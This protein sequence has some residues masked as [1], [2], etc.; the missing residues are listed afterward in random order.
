MTPIAKKPK[1]RPRVSPWNHFSD[2]KTE[3][4]GGDIEVLKNSSATLVFPPES[5]Y[6]DALVAIAS[7]CDPPVAIESLNV[8]L[9]ELRYSPRG[10]TIFRFAGDAIDDIV[11]GAKGNYWWVSR[12]GLNVVKGP[13]PT[14]ALSPFDH[15]AG[16]LCL[17]KLSGN[18]LSR[19]AVREIAKALD[20]A[21]F[22][23]REQLQRAQWKQI[24]VHNQKYARQAVKTFEQAC[25]PTLVRWVRKRLYVARDRYKAFMPPST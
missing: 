10:K 1:T 13:M 17:E 7:H 9:S 20:E 3:E 19:E 16:K 21:A 5:T 15:L 24:A 2:L 23:L 12:S 11:A 22:T 14:V 18:K 4:T 25:R 6:C 8:A